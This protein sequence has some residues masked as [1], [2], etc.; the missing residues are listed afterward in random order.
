MQINCVKPNTIASWRKSHDTL[1]YY[2]KS[3]RIQIRHKGWYYDEL[4][5]GEDE[6]NA[7]VNF[8]LKGFEG[9]IQPSGYTEPILHKKRLEKKLSN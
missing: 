9:K 4:I 7:L 6:E 3:Y 8:F 5:S 1:Y 2:M